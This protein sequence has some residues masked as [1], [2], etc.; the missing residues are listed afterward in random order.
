MEILKTVYLYRRL[1]QRKKQARRRQPIIPVWGN[2]G[3]L[4]LHI[5][6]WKARMMLVWV[7]DE[8]VG[9]KRTQTWECESNK[10]FFPKL[11]WSGLFYHYNRKEVKQRHKLGVLLLHSRARVT[12]GCKSSVSSIQILIS[13][14]IWGKK[15]FSKCLHSPLSSSLDSQPP[16]IPPSFIFSHNYFI[17][18]YLMTVCKKST[19]KS[20]FQN[21]PLSLIILMG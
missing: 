7:W 20:S 11:P 12:R 19:F 21:V 15:V 3:A 14:P 18:E 16:S 2:P 5:T 13:K 9:G 8:C 1:E 6:K 4:F 17:Y 10:P